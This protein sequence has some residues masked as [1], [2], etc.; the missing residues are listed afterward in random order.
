MGFS[1]CLPFRDWLLIALLQLLV[2][3]GESYTLTQP[4]CNQATK[5]QFPLVDAL[6][7]WSCGRL[8]GLTP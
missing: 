2:L 5:A 8:V 4:K 7:C 6:N 1:P 3:V